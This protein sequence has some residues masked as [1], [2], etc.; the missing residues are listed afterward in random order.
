[1]TIDASKA[2]DLREKLAAHIDEARAKLDAL[3]ADL[4]AMREE[5]VETLRGKREEIEKHLAQQKAKAQQMQ[6]DVASWRKEKVAHTQEAIAS[7]RKRRE[8][9]KLL[10]RAQRAEEHARDLVTLA[11]LD[12]EEAEHAILDAVEARHDAHEAFSSA[13]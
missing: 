6:S 3:K 8:I 7:W 12:F 11:A 1:M 5:D 4:A 2:A 13:P 10:A 9:Q